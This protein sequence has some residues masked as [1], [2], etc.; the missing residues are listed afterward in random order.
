MPAKRK[1]KAGNAR[2]ARWWRI[3]TY[4]LVFLW[5]VLGIAAV[6]PAIAAVPGNWRNYI[7]LGAGFVAYLLLREI[8]FLRKNEN[9]L[10]VFSHE[11]SHTVVGLFFGRRIHS[12]NAGQAQGKVSYSGWR[13]GDFFIS[14]APYCLPLIT[15]ALLA[16]RLIGQPELFYVF[17]FLTGLTVA[18]YCHTFAT[19][20]GAYQSDISEQGL[21]RAFVFIVS[22]WI[23]NLTVILLAMRMGLLKAM[24]QILQA[25]WHYIST[26]CTWFFHFLKTLWT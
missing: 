23:F 10:E 24:W 18:F 26:W 7:W 15:Y 25:Y 11:L 6:L 5:L 17:D 21:V 12:F 4:P 16:F 22:A 19:Q 14:L 3:L 20:T 1:L 8:P 13:F 2:A 9:W